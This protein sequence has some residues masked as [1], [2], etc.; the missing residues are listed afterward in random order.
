MASQNT[1]ELPKFIKDYQ[2]LLK[3]TAYPEML[4]DFILSEVGRLYQQVGVLNGFT[5][6]QIKLSVDE[7]V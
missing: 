6:F 4:Q 5:V 3:K 1:P 7:S 2:A